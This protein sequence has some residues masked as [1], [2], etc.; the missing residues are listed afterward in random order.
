MIN[1]MRYEKKKGKCGVLENIHIHPKDD[2]DDDDDD[3][4]NNK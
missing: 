1:I 2:D 3:D 4:D